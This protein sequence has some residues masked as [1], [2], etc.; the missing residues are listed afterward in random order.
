[1][2]HKFWIER[3]EKKEIGFHNSKYH[4]YLTKYFHSLSPKPGDIVFLP[5]CGKTL[6]I[7]FLCELGLNVVGNELVEKAVIE[8][9]EELNR[10]PKI[11]TIDGFKVYEI[12]QV[13]I[14]VGD[15]FKLTS[16]HLGNVKFIFDRGSLVALPDSM[17]SDYAQHL[18]HI[19]PEAHHLLITFEY[20]QSKVSGPPF[21]ISQNEIKKHYPNHQIDHLETINLEAGMKGITPA[22]ECAW[23]IKTK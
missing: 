4:P 3:W 21:S 23:I 1:M 10:V 13:K 20:D 15:F 5:L 19:A 17:R 12:E 8:F 6:D 7:H 22:T 18:K 2:E 11:S 9:F 16:R 14:F